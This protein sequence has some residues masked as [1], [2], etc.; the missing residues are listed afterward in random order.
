MKKLVSAICSLVLSAGFLTSVLTPPAVAAP[1]IQ[2]GLQQQCADVLFLGIRGSGETQDLGNIIRPIASD[3]MADIGASRVVRFAPVEYPAAPTDNLK[4]DAAK[5]IIDPDSAWS[6][7][8]SVDEGVAGARAVL[9]DSKTRCPNEKWV[10]AGYSQGALVAH[11][12][13]TNFFSQEVP[14]IAGVLL[15]ANPGRTPESAVNKSG[16]A[17]EG[18]GLLPLLDIY[19]P[20]YST[21]L[22][23]VTYSLCNTLD[24]VCDT[25][26]NLKS[27]YRPPNGQSLFSYGAN[28][29]H[30]GY[31]SAMS[32]PL[33]EKA[34]KRT[35]EL[36][37]R[38]VMESYKTV[39]PAGA[40]FSGSVAN[41]WASSGPQPV[42]KWDAAEGY[43]PRPGVTSSELG[44][45]LGGGQE[46]MIS[47]SGAYIGRLPAGEYRIPVVMSYLPVPGSTLST[48]TAESG[49]LNLHV[50]DG[51]CGEVRGSVKAASDQAPI[52]S[53]KVTARPYDSAKRAAGEPVRTTNTDVAGEYTL[54]GLPAGQYWVRYE[55]GEGSFFDQYYTGSAP[56]E[57]A[58]SSGTI[59]SVSSANPVAVAD[60]SLA[61]AAS[62]EGIVRDTSGRPVSGISVEGGSS[63]ATSG[64]DG[65]FKISEMWPGNYK[66]ISYYDTTFPRRYV[67]HGYLLF[68]SFANI[69]VR[70]PATIS[71]KVID[72]RGQPIAGA[73]VYA[74]RTGTG[75][76]G[77]YGCYDGSG[78]SD[79]ASAVSN[80]DG[81]YFI[82]GMHGGAEPFTVTA[83]HESA[84]WSASVSGIY[85]Q[86]DG[87]SATNA[88]ITLK[89]HTRITGTVTDKETGSALSGVLM[90]VTGPEGIRNYL[91]GE[92]GKIDLPVTPD[93]NYSI[94]FKLNGYEDYNVG[95]PGGTGAP[96]P[97]TVQSETTK[98]I[99]AGLVKVPATPSQTKRPLYKVVYDASIYELYR[100]SDGSQSPVPLSY[101]KWRDVYNFQ[102]PTSAA[103][104]FVKY[105]WAPMVYAVTFWPGG[106]DRWMWTPL[107][108]Q[109]WQ[110]AGYPTPR[111]AGWIKGSYYYQ[112][113]SSSELF[114][115]SADGVKHKLTY[116]EWADSGFRPYTQRSNEG[117][118][119]LD[120]APE[121]ALMT[122]IAAGTGQPLFYVR[123]EE[124]GFPTP[125]VVR[126]ISGDSFYQNSGSTTIWYK[127]PG[128]ERPVTYGEWT[129]AGSPAPSMR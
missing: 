13:L 115:Q 119:K 83:R 45:S 113:G 40:E 105:R 72:G 46:F 15:V 37:N 112:W 36:T 124:E 108:Y 117:F 127:G 39:C 62:L 97:F 92:D 54:V 60:A 93:A 74:R 57:H 89:Y 2:D 23:S 104:D 29:V 12:V 79:S 81:S 91:T 82:G 6:F 77:I 56:S 71:G 49:F 14:R 43:S 86:R 98:V 9:D 70:R 32:S 53:L 116:Q 69:T 41:H 88:D 99:D 129:A 44:F 17:A 76:Y 47:D 64:A 26:N 27:T 30:T 48:R 75:G 87:G 18:R 78:Y 4:W 114:V 118:L 125:R 100:N 80:A 128:M 63:R 38:T 102:T 24:L 59:L 84:E 28:V 67:D 66:C 101:E 90:S 95:A 73:S 121:F 42:V 61:R 51:D 19:N 55:D 120:W 10:V 31:T 8:A 35:L 5:S 16:S 68:T 126:R 123:W 33:T 110:T 85:A 25:E 34:S 3:F 58:K 22:N 1:V 111:N 21:N 50:L 52:G 20:P 65:L 122:D 96:V 11:R 109:Q 107:S 94:T 103:T 106:E 7:M